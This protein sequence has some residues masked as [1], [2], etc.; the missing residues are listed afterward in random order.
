[1]ND[2]ARPRTPLLDGKEVS[3][4]EALDAL[5]TRIGEMNELYGAGSLAVVGSPR[6][7]LEGALLLPQ[8]AGLLATGALCY[9]S[10]ETE[11]D[12]SAAAVSLLN[13][14]NVASMADV[15]EADCIAILECDLRD[16]GPMMLL[17]ARQAWRKGAPVFLVGKN[18]PLEQARAASMEV[19]ELGILEE[20]PLGIFERPVVICGTRHTSPETIEQLDHAGAKL[21]FLLP[22]PNAFGAA[23]LSREHDSASLAAALADGK[24]KG[25][26]AFEADIPQELPEGVELLAVADWLPTEAVKHAH[27][28]LPTAAWTEADGTFVNNEGRAQRFRRVMNAGYPIKGL[29]ARYQASADKPAPLHPPRVHRKEPPGG[30]VRPAWQVIAELLQRLGAEQTDPF[31]GGWKKLRDLDPESTGVRLL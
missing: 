1:V 17:A 4:D 26:L 22:G 30:A 28:V 13:G 16:E 24:V 9:F 21:A 19:I 11:G 6:L 29:P 18:A 10:D 2:P 15:R 23:L 12:R 8:L 25:V 7:A 5:I 27:I 20:A 31:T 3:W 14:A